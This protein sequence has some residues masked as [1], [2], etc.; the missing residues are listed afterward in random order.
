MVCDWLGV[1]V[2]LRLYHVSNIM[3]AN[4]VW[5]AELTSRCEFVN[6]CVRVL[7][8]SYG[9]QYAR[10]LVLSVFCYTQC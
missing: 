10:D 8:S 9:G 1:C 2:W 5:P 4:S 6:S 7:L 3:S